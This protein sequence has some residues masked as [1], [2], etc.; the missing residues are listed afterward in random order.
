MK[1]RKKKGIGEEVM[2]KRPLAGRVAMGNQSGEA[3]SSFLCGRSAVSQVRRP[4]YYRRL[5]LRL[6]NELQLR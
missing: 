2:L 6:Q 3:I 5:R 4:Y 1:K